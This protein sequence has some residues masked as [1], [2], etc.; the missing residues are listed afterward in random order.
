VIW[1]QLEAA[2]Y[3]PKHGFHNLGAWVG[4]IERPRPGVWSRVFISSSRTF[5]A[6][7]NAAGAFASTDFWNRSWI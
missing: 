2:K 3:E 6:A 1:K 5:A 4:L 7:L